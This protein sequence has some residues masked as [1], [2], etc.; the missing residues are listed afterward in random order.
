MM[1]GARSLDARL[2]QDFVADHVGG[3][4]RA[5]D[6][7]AEPATVRW[8]ERLDCDFEIP[9]IHAELSGDLEGLDV[10]VAASRV[11]TAC[12]ISCCSRL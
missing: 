3:Q 10:I 5:V 11:K 1:A 8:R 9:R 2:V 7:F 6:I 4:L 12:G